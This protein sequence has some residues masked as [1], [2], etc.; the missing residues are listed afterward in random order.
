MW[1]AGDGARVFFCMNSLLSEV[2][3]WFVLQ[4]IDL[5]PLPH[6]SDEHF[7][8]SVSSRR[9]LLLLTFCFLA[10]HLLVRISWS[11]LV[12]LRWKETLWLLDQSTTIQHSLHF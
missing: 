10:Q 9:L 7:L 8:C 2:D 3:Y 6:L 12:R 1:P 11:G 5:P 4:G